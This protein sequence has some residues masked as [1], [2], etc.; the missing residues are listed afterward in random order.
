V[1]DEKEFRV[2]IALPGLEAE[3]IQLSAMPDG[4]VI[5]ADAMHTHE[6]ERGNVWFCEFSRKKLFRRLQLPAS[7][8]VDKVTASVDKG[9]LEVTAP[10]AT[11]STKGE[12]VVRMSEPTAKSQRPEDG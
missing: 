3:D 7:I 9:I 6:G 5:Q 4:L 2:R 12:F 1:E 8:D 10:K 11:A